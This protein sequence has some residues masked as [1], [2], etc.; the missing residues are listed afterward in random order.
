[1]YTHW[2]WHTAPEWVKSH[3]PRN[4]DDVTWVRLY[5]RATA[6]DIGGYGFG[7]VHRPG[8]VF[9]TWHNKGLL[10]WRFHA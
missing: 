4:G 3:A 9:V 8:D 10:V 7:G 6:F 2:D 1:M 5:D